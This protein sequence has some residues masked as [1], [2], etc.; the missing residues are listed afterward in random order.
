[1]PRMLVKISRKK[2]VSLL[3]TRHNDVN[4]QKVSKWT[5]VILYWRQRPN[6]NNLN[7]LVFGNPGS[8]SLDVDSYPFFSCLCNINFN[9]VRLTP[10]EYIFALR[11]H[12]QIQHRLQ[13]F[14]TSVRTL[15]LFPK[16]IAPISFCSWLKLQWWISKFAKREKKIWILPSLID[17]V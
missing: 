9:Y 10:G 12:W 3:C 14:P 13:F 11:S 1:M 2:K 8:T 4:K 16:L 7:W 15:I 17:T 5:G 6:Q